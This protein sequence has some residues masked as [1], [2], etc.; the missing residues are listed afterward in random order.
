MNIFE[1]TVSYYKNV[2]D[3][4]GTKIQLYTF[5]TSAKHATKVTELRAAVAAGLPAEDVLKIKK[6]LPACTV[7]GL[8]TERTAAGL[9]AHSGFIAI[10]IDAKD[11]MHLTN[12]AEVKNELCKL[13]EIAYCGLS[14]SGRGYFAL[15]RLAYPDRHAEQF[16]ALYERFF[17]MGLVIDQACKDVTRLRFYSYDAEAF[18]NFD[19]QPF[20]GVTVNGNGTV[21][22]GKKTT[23][24]YFTVCPKNIHNI[25]DAEKLTDLLAWCNATHTDI[26]GNYRAWYEIG[27]GLA[28]ELGEAGRDIFHD[29]SAHYAGYD[30]LKTDKQYNYCLKHQH[31]FTLASVFHYAKLAGWQ[32][33]TVNGNGTVNNGNGTVKSGLAQLVAPTQTDAERLAQMEKD[34]P[35]L[36]ELCRRIDLTLENFTVTG[37]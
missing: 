28:S 17:N 22:N 13:K 6:T 19:A 15:I 26:T 14:C 8:F 7:S 33:V 31:S 5:L 9:V 35:E 3:T 25:T 24:P 32:G 4:T 36:V 18:Y 34:N 11:N 2:T 27:A 23:L 1:K 12:F 16:A 20:T 21:N 37:G 29:L 10:D 30:Y